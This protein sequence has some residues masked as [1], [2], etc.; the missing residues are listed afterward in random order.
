VEGDEVRHVSIGTIKTDEEKKKGGDDIW[1]EFIFGGKRIL[2]PDGCEERDSQDS[3]RGEANSGDQESLDGVHVR[4]ARLTRKANSNVESLW[5]QGLGTFELFGES[6]SSGDTEIFLG[7][8]VWRSKVHCEPLEMDA[9]PAEKSCKDDCPKA[10]RTCA[11]SGFLFKFGRMAPDSAPPKVQEWLHNIGC[12]AEVARVNIGTVST[13]P[14]WRPFLWIQPTSPC[15]FVVNAT[16]LGGLGGKLTL[17]VKPKLKFG[18]PP[19]GIDKVSDTGGLRLATQN[20]DDPAAP[21]EFNLPTSLTSMA[22]MG[23]DSSTSFGLSGL[24]W[25][26]YHMGTIGAPVN[27]RGSCRS[28]DGGLLIPDGAV[29]CG[30][31]PTPAHDP[32]PASNCPTDILTI[33]ENVN[34]LALNFGMLPFLG[35]H[36][37]IITQLT[38]GSTPLYA[39]GQVVKAARFVGLTFGAGKTLDPV[40]TIFDMQV[41]D[42]II[43]PGRIDV[44]FT[45]LSEP[46]TYRWGTERIP[47]RLNSASCEESIKQGGSYTISNDLLVS[48]DNS[49]VMTT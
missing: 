14:I 26:H 25:T 42:V 2:G 20:P 40:V 43:L 10:R 44:R 7:T 11:N 15:P 18:W 36:P 35:N 47:F 24:T 16:T 13:H 6:C 17:G 5:V 31:P 38:A 22:L 34:F 33:L 23:S 30:L 9:V 46:C 4:V 19:I 28:S 41:D 3:A 21:S 1:R 27:W 37:G 49:Q 32:A 12:E 29:D 39:R 48:G 8:I 45:V